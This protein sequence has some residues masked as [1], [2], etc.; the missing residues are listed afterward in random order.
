AADDARLGRADVAEAAGCAGVLL[1]AEVAD[2][3]EH[4]AA[5]GLRE[6]ADLFALGELVR[7]LRLVG[8]APAG[9]AAGDVLLGVELHPAVDP[10]L[11]DRLLELLGVHRERLAETVGGERGR[12]GQA[13]DLLQ[14]RG[15]RVVAGVEEFVAPAV[16][17]GVEE[18]GAGGAAVAAGAA[19]LL[20]VAFEAPREAGVNHRADVRLV[21]P[22]AEGDGGD[23]HLDG[24]GEEARPAPVPGD[25]GRL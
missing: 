19:D 2:H 18:D 9:A 7:A 11:L 3:V 17:V 1:V 4:A 10:Q 15:L 8:D 12:D 16:G 24:A 13:E 21:H 22:H 23:D 6:A 20:V 14:D 25:A 5:V